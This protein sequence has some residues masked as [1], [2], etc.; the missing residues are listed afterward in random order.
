M[1]KKEHVVRTEAV[2]LLNGNLRV[3]LNVHSS[4][5]N[6]KPNRTVNASALKRDPLR[7]KVALPPTPKLIRIDAEEGDVNEVGWS[8]KG[9]VPGEGHLANSDEFESRASPFSVQREKP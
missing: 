7:N 6:S 8:R 9:S 1:A 3:L 2:I 5:K 4:P